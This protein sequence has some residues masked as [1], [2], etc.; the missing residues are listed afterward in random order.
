[1]SFWNFLR[2]MFYYHFWY[3][4]FFGGDNNS[5]HNCDCD[6]GGNCDCG[7]N[8]GDGFF[9]PFTIVSPFCPWSPFWDHDDD[10]DD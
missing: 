2:K 4:I 8:Q 9:D 6:D 7:D 5:R 3:S 10:D 1:M